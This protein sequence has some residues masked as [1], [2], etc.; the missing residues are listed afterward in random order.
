MLGKEPESL[1]FVE[2]SRH[3]LYKIS[4]AVWLQ[5]GWSLWKQ[6]KLW[7]KSPLSSGNYGRNGP[8]CKGKTISHLIRSQTPVLIPAGEVEGLYPLSYGCVWGYYAAGSTEV[9]F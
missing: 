3:S 7:I 9:K 6:W 4:G 1:Y 8:L 5:L 2:S